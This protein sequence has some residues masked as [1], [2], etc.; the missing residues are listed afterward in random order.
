MVFR[1]ARIYLEK[2]EPKQEL[3]QSNDSIIN[4]DYKKGDVREE[5]WYDFRGNDT[6]LSLLRAD[7]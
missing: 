5:E 7:E 3:E 1:Q 4:D 2:W 6:C